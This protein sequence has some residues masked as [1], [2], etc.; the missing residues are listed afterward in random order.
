MNTQN[1]STLPRVL[2]VGAGAIGSLYGALLA[3]QGAEVSVVCRSDYDT[4]RERGFHI[5]SPLGDLSFRPAAV[6][7]S[8]AEYAGE[9]DYLLLCVKV[10]DDTERAALIR[11]AVG[12]RTAIVL[13]ENGIEIEPPLAQAFPDNP[14]ISAAAYVAVGRTGPGRVRHSAY[15]RL[16]MGE[17]PRGAG[18]ATHDLAALLA[19]AGVACDVSDDVV[20]ARWQKA[21]WNVAFN[22]AS[23]LAGGADT[24]CLLATPDGEALI[25]RLIEEVCAVAAACGHP[26]D[27][28]ALEKSIVATRE[29]PPHRTSMALDY[30]HGRAMETEAIIG[31]V[32]RAARREAVA[33][34]A[35]ETVYALMQMAETRL[36]RQSSSS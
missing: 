4:V 15:G 9:P 34:P 16:V 35:L 8:A 1:A 2:V 13:I 12:P 36:A 7:R 11:P 6:L 29:M 26:L 32:V 20:T 23:V 17:Y 30:L 22:P 3:H 28:C 10:L 25:R 18:P 24:A 27:T 31:N 19:A 21:A 14:L 33:V 5:D